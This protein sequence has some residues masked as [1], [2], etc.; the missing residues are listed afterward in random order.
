MLFMI[1]ERFH[2]GKVKTLYERFA[3]K[4]RMLPEGVNYVNS[5]INEELTICYQVMESYSRKSIDEWISYRDDLAD[6]EVLPV[7]T[8]G[9][10]KARIFL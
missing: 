3:E 8:S 5:W 1:I 2:E 10:A 9:E 6:F 7:I 4:G